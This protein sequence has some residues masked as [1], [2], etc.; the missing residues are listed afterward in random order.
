MP[1]PHPGLLAGVRRVA[2]LAG[3]NEAD[4]GDAT[5]F[6]GIGLCLAGELIDGHAGFLDASGA[7]KG[8]SLGRVRTTSSG[9]STPAATMDC[10]GDRLAM[11]QK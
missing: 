2:A 7:R 5:G 6:A 11:A 8:A 9:K 3:T 10:N 1:L 4:G